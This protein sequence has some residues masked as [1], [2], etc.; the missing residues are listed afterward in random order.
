[1][2]KTFAALS[3]FCLT[4]AYGAAIIK[5]TV[6][7]EVKDN[8]ERAYYLWKHN[9][10]KGFIKFMTLNQCQILFQGA[11]INILDENGNYLK[12][13]PVNLRELWVRKGVVSK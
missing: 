10:S 3:L 8:V 1:M 9:G 5:K 13:T 4:T 12:V 6:G 7:C 2:I 11:K